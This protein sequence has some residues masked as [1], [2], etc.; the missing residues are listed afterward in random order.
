M[1]IKRVK[2]LNF[3]T[4][5]DQTVVFDSGYNTIVGQNGSGKTNFFEAIRFVLGDGPFADLGSRQ[6]RLRYIHGGGVN[7]TDASVELV[8]DNRDGR[9]PTP[10]PELSLRR[11]INQLKEE[12]FLDDKP[13]RREEILSL[14]ES[15]GF[16]QTNPFYIVPQ[17]RISS[18]AEERDEERL[19]LLQG[20]AGTQIF[21]EKKA[22]ARRLLDL[23]QEQRA[24]VDDAVG[25]IAGRLAELTQELADLR[26]F[27][28]LD[29][30]RRGLSRALY[31]RE[32][33]E[34]QAHLQE[35]SVAA[36]GASGLGP[37]DMAAYQ[38]PR[39]RARQAAHGSLAGST[40]ARLGQAHRLDSQ[41][42]TLADQEEALRRSRED[43][44]IGQEQLRQHAARLF[45]LSAAATRLEARLELEAR[46]GE[47]TAGLTRRRAAL[48][49]ALDAAQIRQQEL[50]GRVDQL[51]DDRR[52]LA[53]SLGQTRSLLAAL[54]AVATLP[55]DGPGRAEWVADQ[56]RQAA[57]AVRQLEADLATLQDRVASAQREAADPAAAARRLDANVTAAEDAATAAAAA[58]AEA[59]RQWKDLADARQQA[60]RRQG[61][62][63]H[64]LARQYA[65]ALRADH[66]LQRALPGPTRRGLASLAEW[67]LAQGVAPG[68]WLVPPERLVAM[69]DMSQ[70]GSESASAVVEAIAGAAEAATARCCFGPF[71]GLLQG[72]PEEL[73]TAVQA[74]AGG[75]LHYVVVADDSVAQA[76][77]DW[78]RSG[79]GRQ[80]AVTFAPLTVAGST[81]AGPDEEWSY[82]DSCRSFELELRPYVQPRFHPILRMLFAGYAL[83][84]DVRTGTQAADRYGITCVTL[85]GDVISPT[86]TLTGGFRNARRA[87]LPASDQAARARAA[88][89]VRAVAGA[90]A[91]A[92]LRAL[93]EDVRRLELGPLAAAQLAVGAA[94]EQVRQ[95]RAAR[96]ALDDELAQLEGLA[97]R[98][99]SQTQAADRARQRF[100][101][102]DTMLED[103]GR[104]GGPA[105]EAQRMALRAEEASLQERLAGAEQMAQALGSEGAA[106]G[107][108]V[109]N[110][111]RQLQ[112]I[113]QHLSARG[114]EGDSTADPQADRLAWLQAELARSNQE[115]A[116]C[117]AER[118][119]KERAVAEAA[120]RTTA[121]E[122]QIQNSKNSFRRMFR[123]EQR[124]MSQR[125]RAQESQQL[126][127]ERIAWLEH[128]L[129]DLELSELDQAVAASGRPESPSNVDAQLATPDL[130]AALEAINAQLADYRHVNRHAVELHGAYADNLRQAQARLQ[131]LDQSAASIGRLME[132][133]EQTREEA[134]ERTLTSVAGHFG[135]VFAELVSAGRGE[136][137]LERSSGPSGRLTGVSVHVAFGE[138]TGPSGSEPL[139]DLRPIQALSGGQKTLVALSLIF[140]IQRF[141]PAPFYLLDEVDAH[142]DPVHRAAV[143]EAG[144]VV[145][146]EQQGGCI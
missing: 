18:V 28:R 71:F 76:F 113:E 144:D 57:E 26:E 131:Q 95:A 83:C 46:S 53:A 60:G 31:A 139:A 8:L 77:H 16:S 33:Q 47:A 30:R 109:A 142:L 106:L 134:I 42:A 112:S 118:R 9:L 93:D 2:I 132:F 51:A 12:Y 32:L 81:A 120:R 3:L 122:A 78:S 50:H 34:S 138:P 103:V 124:A 86:G 108:H 114:P 92:A 96:E 140:A 105:A 85:E 72:V 128:Q 119:E 43:E 36:G 44:R 64:A 80:G 146:G 74:A 13:K 7:F 125:D 41:Q 58:H 90:A 130:M 6:T 145:P 63:Q 70:L 91:A 56:R 136:L 5:R 62:E 84:P 17:G 59:T 99:A 14:L 129:E 40:P 143:A 117:E 123:D 107:S 97:A 15:V 54:Q 10:K 61:D 38:T 19:A 11:T 25:Q 66:H 37:G 115:L 82:P 4:F 98:L 101:E 69:E 27:N 68:W 127:R 121:L 88:Y 21:E 141:D 22:D 102:L 110:L 65:D 94:A 135:Q 133:L 55:A 104:A 111:E 73:S 48:Q 49:R 45:Q 75:R 126:L 20:I 137:R 67:S 39:S 100:A 29:A 35:L 24:Q 23:T 1:F 52:D 87:L 116:A 89:H 79:P